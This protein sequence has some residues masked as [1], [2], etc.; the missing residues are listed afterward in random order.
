MKLLGKLLI[1]MK[2]V[3][4]FGYVCVSSNGQM[5]KGGPERQPGNAKPRSS[6]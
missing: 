1:N 5:D 6:S 4:A 2:K 3:K